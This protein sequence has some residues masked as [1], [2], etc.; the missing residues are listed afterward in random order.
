MYLTAAVIQ[1][2]LYLQQ[3]F[4]CVFIKLVSFVG[5]L[6]QYRRKHPFKEYVTDHKRKNNADQLVKEWKGVNSIEDFHPL[7][8]DFILAELIVPNFL[9][10]SI[11]S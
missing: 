11:E 8:F 3:R 5:L 7:G 4:N 2:Y 10:K 1:I 6:S 9:E